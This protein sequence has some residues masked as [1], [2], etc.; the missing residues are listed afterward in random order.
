M[1][2]FLKLWSRDGPIPDFCRY[3]DI[4][5]CRY[6]DIADANTAGKSNFFDCRYRYCRYWKMCRYADISDTDTGIGPSLLWSLHL[7][8][9]LFSILQYADVDL[10]MVR[11][12]G[13]TW[14]TSWLDSADNTISLSGWFQVLVPKR[15]TYGFSVAYSSGPGFMLHVMAPYSKHTAP[16]YI[17]G[18]LRKSK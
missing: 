16:L 5:L 9:S 11:S 3:A 4:D 2:L 12:T 1:T 18:L 14:I 13:G 6:A 15:A 8:V 17:N 7:D 10:S